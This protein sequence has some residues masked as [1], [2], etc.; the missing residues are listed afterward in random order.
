VVGKELP[1]FE[2][3]TKKMAAALRMIPPVEDE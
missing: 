2:D 3:G 1:S